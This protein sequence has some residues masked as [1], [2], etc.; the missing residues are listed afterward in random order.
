M[1]GHPRK[2]SSSSNAPYHH[3]RPLLQC[4][5]VVIVVVATLLLIIQMH[6]LARVA[7]VSTSIDQYL[8]QQLEIH[9]ID[10]LSTYTVDHP[11]TNHSKAS[12]YKNEKN[13]PHDYDDNNNDDDEDDLKPILKILHQAGYD[14]TND[15]EIQKESLPRWSTIQKAYGPPKIIGLESCAQYQSTVPQK[16]QHLGV[17]GLFNSGTNVLHSLLATNCRPGSAQKVK[18]QVRSL[19]TE[20]GLIIVYYFLITILLLTQCYYYYYYYF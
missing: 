16:Y 5:L 4:V 1:K 14:I 10:I 13:N 8:N 17:A 7:D 6:I 15:E 12:I 11:R 19:N 20:L 3:H 18:W 2:S 9:N